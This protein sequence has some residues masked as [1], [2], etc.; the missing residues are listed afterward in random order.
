[1]ILSSVL[2]PEPLSPMMPTH[3]PSSTSKADVLQ[4]CEGLI[5]VRS[6]QACQVLEEGGPTLM[7]DLEGLPEVLYCYNHQIASANLGSRR[8]K[9]M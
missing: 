7:R 8:S 1:M 6:H 4:Y 9:M 2:L 5:V 3:S